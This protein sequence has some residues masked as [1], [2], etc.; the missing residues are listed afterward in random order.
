MGCMSLSF[1]VG[2]TIMGM[3]VDSVGPQPR[4]GYEPLVFAISLAPVECDVGFQCGLSHGL[5]R[6]GIGVGLLEV[7][8][9][10]LCNCVHGL[11]SWNSASLLVA[12]KDPSTDRLIPK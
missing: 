7:G 6:N 10:S 12:G 2:L 9:K 3:L 8:S 11:V 4:V 1:V 5:R